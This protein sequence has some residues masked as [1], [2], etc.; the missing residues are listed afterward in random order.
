MTTWKKPASSILYELEAERIQLQEALDAER[1]AKERNIL[2]QFATPAPLAEDIIRYC[3][4][5]HTREK[6]NFLEPSCGSG[7]FFSALVR[8][9]NKD[10]LADAVGVEVDERFANAATALWSAHGLR[11]INGDFTKSSTLQ[12]FR[13][14]LLVTNPPYVRH[15][16][17]STNE[18]KRLI[19][20][21]TQQLSI[22]PSGLSGL[23]LYFTLLSHRLLAPDAISAWLIPAEFMD[24]N[25]GR[26]LKEYL[27]EQVSLIR[28]H[29]FDPADVQF[30]D[31]LVTSAVVV[32]KN[33]PPVKGQVVEFSVGGSVE[34]PRHI[35]TRPLDELKPTTKWATHFKNEFRNNTSGP[36]LKDFL[37]VRRGLA[38]GSNSF[39]IL[40]RKR[41]QELG[42]RPEHALPILPSPRVLKGLVVERREDG[43]PDI[44]EPLA[45][46]TSCLTEDEL[47][48]RDPGLA[49]YLA[50]ADEKI[51]SGYLVSKRSP[52]YKQENRPPAPFLCT[53]MGRGTDDKHPFRFIL[54]K[55]EAT[56]T[57]LYLMLYPT[58]IMQAYI[59]RHEGALE[60]IHKALLSLTADDLRDGG[61]VYG[62][63]L[64]KIE[65]K[66][67]G[68]LRADAL[69]ELFS[70][71]ELAGTPW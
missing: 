50:S 59:D 66:E 54:N 29:R 10:R 61:R 67:L 45:L 19:S 42:I 70:D 57:N 7:S 49:Q 30:T 14:S 38:T 32:F 40:P 51:K 65:P 21:V 64:H 28:I 56:A 11:V 69:L 52:W 34:R 8:S 41:V 63:G 13:A 44:D 23:Y 31:A 43:Y 26:A 39:F 27:T 35:I 71:E 48:T 18:K 16:H 62:G 37:R 5:L 24:V 47:R 22:T 36:T 3:L 33:T 20:A 2:G 17:L 9:V 46:I 25:Y 58:P 60:H 12:D 55:S 53:Y 68:N 1:T 4:S 15:H 6:I